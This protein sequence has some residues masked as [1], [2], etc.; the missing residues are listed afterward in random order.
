MRAKKL[1]TVVLIF[2]I[3]L[4]VSSCISESAEINAAA[5]TSKEGIPVPIIMYH[6]VCDNAPVSSEYI[7]GVSQFRQDMEYLSYRGY[8]TIF[9]SDLVNYV[10]RGSAL[11]EKPV[12]ITFDDGHLNNLISVYP[13]LEELDMKAVISVVGSFTEAYSAISDRDQSYAYLTFDDITD[14]CDSGRIEIGNHTYNMH[15][16]DTRLGCKIKSGESEEAYSLVLKED[17]L[18]LQRTLLENCGFTPEV[19]AYPYGYM[20]KEAE[21]VL[22]ELG[23]ASALTC[24]EEVNYITGD[25]EQLFSLGR[26]NRSSIYS[27]SDFMNKL[28]IK[29]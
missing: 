5:P 2:C 22:K 13:I 4:S 8:K 19:F 29:D 21:P 11:P 12:I 3:M 16:T 24:T 28:G 10:R 18:H 9:V 20:C 7:L 15:R 6:S 17:L 25:P 23:F 26:F 14:L 27:T 1:L